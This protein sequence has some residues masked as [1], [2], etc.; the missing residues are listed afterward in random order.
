MLAPP[1]ELELELLEDVISV[2]VRP[3]AAGGGRFLCCES[4]RRRAGVDVNGDGD[5][6]GDGEGDG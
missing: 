2:T 6:D 5:G 1:F 4:I 3:M